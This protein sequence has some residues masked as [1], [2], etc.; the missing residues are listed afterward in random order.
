M[1]K[2]YSN[3]EFRGCLHDGL[4]IHGETE[5]TVAGETVSRETFKWCPDCGAIRIDDVWRYPRR[6]LQR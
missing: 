5:I 4:S 2:P 3:P 6:V 1:A